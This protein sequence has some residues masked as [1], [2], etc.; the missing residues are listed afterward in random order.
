MQYRARQKETSTAETPQRTGHDN[1]AINAEARRVVADRLRVI[2]R[3][4]AY[5]AL[6][7][8]GGSQLQNL[9]LQCV[10]CRCEC[11]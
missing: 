4:V 11:A 2:A 3:R 5:D 8:L 6:G 7:A 9:V 10:D 1:Q